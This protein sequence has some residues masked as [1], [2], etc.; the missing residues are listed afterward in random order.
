MNVKIPVELTFL[1]EKEKV[2]QFVH[3]V[4]WK[5]SKLLMKYNIFHEDMYKPTNTFSNE[6]PSFSNINNIDFKN[7]DKLLNISKYKENLLFQN[8]DNINL[9]QELITIYQKV[10]IYKYNY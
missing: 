9:V 7:I 2:Q 4:Q 8:S 6:L 3:K 1:F 10:S 5:V